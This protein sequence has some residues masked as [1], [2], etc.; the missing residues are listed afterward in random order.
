MV[1][2]PCREYVAFFYPTPCEETRPQFAVYHRRECEAGMRRRE[3]AAE[4]P[5][6]FSFLLLLTI[7]C[8]DA[9]FV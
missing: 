6:S 2:P 4:L 9:I 7:S 5:P 3:A 1:I 8:Y